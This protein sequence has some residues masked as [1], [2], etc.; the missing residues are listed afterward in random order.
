MFPDLK[1]E[2][3]GTLLNIFII[4]GDTDMRRKAR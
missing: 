4:E 2:N 3:S 1:K